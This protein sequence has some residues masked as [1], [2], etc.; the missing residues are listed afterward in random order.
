ME[1]L[2]IL[3]VLD[4]YIIEQEAGYYVKFECKAV[5]KSESRPHG[6]K[7]SLTLHDKNH[8]RKLGF[9]NAHPVKPRK[10]FKYAGQ[11]LSY[12]HEHKSGTD[13]IFPYNFLS[14]EMLLSDFYKSVDKYLAGVL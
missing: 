1:N 7:Y 13:E 12:D 2:E 3:L 5:E 14:A 6:L 11:I 9:D 4:G 10:G 8:Q